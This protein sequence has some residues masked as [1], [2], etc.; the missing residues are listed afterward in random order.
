M[1]ILGNAWIVV[2]ERTQMIFNGNHAV[3]K[4]GAIFATQTEQ[5]YSGYSHTCFIRYSNPYAHPRDWDATFTFVNN[6]AFNEQNS[7]YAASLLPCLW[8]VANNSSLKEDIDMAFCW[9]GWKYNQRSDCTNEIVTSPVAL[10]RENPS[11]SLNFF[12]GRPQPL[13]VIA[14]DDKKHNVTKQTIFT[15]SSLNQDI[16]LN[17]LY[18]S[19]NTLALSGS[20]DTSTTISLE[21]FDST[22]VS[23]DLNVSI[24]PCPVG[25]VYNTSTRD[26]K[27]S[28]EQEFGGLVEC[29]EN[30][31]QV[32]TF[33][34]CCISTSSSDN[35]TNTTVIAA[36]CPFTLGYQQTMLAI[37]ITSTV[38]DI[39]RLFCQKQL[40][41]KGRLCSKYEENYGI[42]PFSATMECVPCKNTYKN[43]LKYFAQGFLPSTIFFLTIILFHIGVTSAPANA[44]I[45]FSQVTALPLHQLLL[46]TGLSLAAKSNSTAAILTDVLL[47]PY[48]VW[49]LDFSYGVTAKYC[50]D[51][52]FSGIDILALQYLSAIYP[53]ILVGVAFVILQL[54]ARNCRPLVCICRPFCIFIARIRRIWQPKTSVV[55][56]FATAILLSYTK[57]IVVSLSLL[58]PARVYDITGKEVDVVLKYD[59]SIHFFQG[60]HIPY[61]IISIIVLLIFGLISPMILLLYPFKWFQQILNR[62]RLNSAALQ[63]FADAFQGCYKNGTNGTP[64]R[65]FFAGLYFLF[66]NVIFVL[67]TVLED[68]LW[69]VLDYTA[70]FYVLGQ[71]SF[72]F[73]QPY[74][75]TFYNCLDACFMSLLA[76]INIQTVFNFYHV[77][78]FSF[79]LSWISI[80]GLTFV[81]LV[82]IHGFILYRFV[83]CSQFFQ[84]CCIFN[85]KCCKKT[86]QDRI[87]LINHPVSHDEASDDDM[88]PHRLTNPHLYR[89]TPETENS[90]YCQWEHANEQS[91]LRP[92]STSGYGST[93]TNDTY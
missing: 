3:E 72:I 84:K 57:L 9:K 29:S 11:T 30:E 92:R 93:V 41:R 56:A 86:E 65:R 54:H 2:H 6:L 21:T 64:D 18:V 15:A 69:G 48:G 62:C 71:L 16:D 68:N 78:N 52:S 53:L 42:E 37:N 60:K 17:V 76:I 50:L 89:S 32:R 67:Y 88:L 4:G 12:S 81:P 38:T 58:A 40:H 34:G 74:K 82:Y 28:G 5:H 26:C 61:G 33:V 10:E 90:S 70:S 49:N 46:Q 77:R 75:Q 1:T 47:L 45:F 31:F 66:R 43:W 13:G 27:C 73:F 79:S 36:R 63:A 22:A 8:P 44:F 25:F 7:I 51:S 35:N 59:P 23:L 83:I 24:L 14:L 91:L 80:Y 87:S 19:D 55:D 39:D 20:P 85:L